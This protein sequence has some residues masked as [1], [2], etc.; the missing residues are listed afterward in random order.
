MKKNTIN[1]L[2]CIVMSI[3]AISCSSTVKPSPEA[4][5]I[6]IYTTKE[7]LPSGCISLKVELTG[8]GSSE[9]EAQYDLAHQ[10]QEEYTADSLLLLKVQDFTQDVRLS[11][12]LRTPELKAPKPATYFYYEDP[13]TIKAT[14]KALRCKL[15]KPRELS[16]IK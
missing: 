7:S 15:I 1:A 16:L 10:A 3:T 2:V 8:Y 14:G 5:Q 11:N 4:T 9:L 13:F 12:Y 6:T